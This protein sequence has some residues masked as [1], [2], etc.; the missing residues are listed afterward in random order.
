M[1]P[2]FMLVL[3]AALGACDDTEQHAS[4][5]DPVP[6]TAEATAH[7]C[8]MGL[9]EMPGPKGQI[10]LDGLPDPIWFAQVRDA[11]AFLKS[12]ERM[13]RVRA[14]YVPDM[15]RAPSWALPGADNWIAAE[16]AHFVLGSSRRGAMG[17]PEIVPFA[18][19]A[20]AAEFA[21][22]HGG[23]VLRLDAVPAEAVLGPVEIDIDRAGETL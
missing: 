18:E 9:A 6:L 2:L 7:F 4:A 20:A 15:G 14:V 12:P 1:R 13:G 5:P 22:A 16:A 21:A 23:R 8:Q 11:L 19:A 3:L 17:A 10:H